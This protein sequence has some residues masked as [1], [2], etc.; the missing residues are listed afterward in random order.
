MT[1][2]HPD[3]LDRLD[4][5]FVG[6][7]C[8]FLDQL[9]GALNQSDHPDVVEVLRLAMGVRGSLEM[10]GAALVAQLAGALEE[11]ALALA[12]GRVSWSDELLDLARDTADQLQTLLLTI[13]GWGSEEDNR[14]LHYL[15]RWSA[16]GSDGSDAAAVP[17][18]TDTS[19]VSI[20]ALFFEAT[21]ATDLAESTLAVLIEDILFDA[22]DTDT[23]DADLPEESPG[24]AE[25]A[26]IPIGF[27][28]VEDE[29]E[30]NGE[31][32]AEA[33]DVVAMTDL[34]MDDEAEN[35][36]EEN[37]ATEEDADPA[38][39]D[40]LLMDS[41]G[42][43]VSI[44]N[45]LESSTDEVEAISIE[46]LF[47]EEPETVLIDQLLADDQSTDEPS[48]PSAEHQSKNQLSE[49]E[50]PVAALSIDDLLID[51]LLVDGLS[52]DDLLMDE[53]ESSFDRL[54][55]EDLLYDPEADAACSDG[56]AEEPESTGNPDISPD[57]PSLEDAEASL[58][59]N[60]LLHDRESALRQAAAMREAV[61]AAVRG[62]PLDS[63]PLEALVRELFDLLELSLEADS[64]GE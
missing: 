43:I 22:S 1:S 27:L 3:R 37:E 60:S 32:E 9:R 64:R 23:P 63:R 28:L 42:G 31:Q 45:L 35:E 17:V 12:D 33:R 10:A 54:S 49:D 16:L 20:E 21:E 26:V 55:I 58:L 57:S 62:E 15:E 13:S 47:E 50:P 52:I 56:P 38:P 46:S 4:E 51:D 41:D 53:D 5:Y 19:A 29:A 34:L 8:D 18:D 44:E 61:E 36:G 25:P 40:G 6:E 59:I 30:E 14:V 24:G 39:F 2:D 11:V 7:A 48:D